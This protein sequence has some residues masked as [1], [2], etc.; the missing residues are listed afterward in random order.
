MAFLI[1]SKKGMELG[2]R[3]LSG[4]AVIGRSPECDISIHDILLSRRH[5]RVQPAD[6]GWVLIDLNSRNGTRV[7]GE[8]VDRRLLRHGDELIVGKTVARF[9]AG[10]LAESPPRWNSIGRR[11]AD[12]FEA[13]AGT[14]T[15]FDAKAALAA[16]RRLKLPRPQPVPP[17]PDSYDRENVYSMLTEIASSSWD[18]I[19]ATASRPRRRLPE[20]SVV[21]LAPPAAVAR[22]G[23]RPRVAA[24]DRSGLLRRTVGSVGRGLAAVRKWVAPDGAVRLI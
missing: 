14:V 1:F 24:T 9:E 12:P 4:P 21:S 23:G 7:N 8:R 6:E 5:C 19:Y 2:R 13:L 15:E 22:P 20:R 16:Q 11:P 3:S 10:E 17:E 18:S